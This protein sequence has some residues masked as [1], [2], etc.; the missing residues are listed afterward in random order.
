MFDWLLLIAA[1][2]LA[3]GL[4][5]MAGGGSFLT[6]PALVFTGVSPIVAN[7]TSAVA[8]F[9]GY[10]GAVAGFR[11]E[12]A[13][14]KKAKLIITFLLCLV[15]GFIG[16]LLL[17]VTSETV[18]S[19]IVPWL[20]LFAT[21]VFAF[22]DRV[23]LIQG[24]ADS[25]TSAKEMVALLFVSIYGGYFNGGLGIILLAV[26]LLSGFA[27]IHLM[28]GLKNGA[29]VC[30]GAISVATFAAAGLVLWPQALVMM[31]GTTLGG[32]Y[33]AALAK[34]IPGKLMK[35]CITVIGLLM[36]LIFFL[37]T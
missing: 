18:F 31:A 4:N 17:L 25:S 16:S 30:I 3:G 27:D 11:S 33:G 12:L 35:W 15:G 9:P 28:N 21:L 8:V 36:S 37:R 22:G 14:V 24:R 29:S 1:S 32:Y 6:L 26:F 23:I 10:I 7:A 13:L 19:A 5:A 2:I 34:R 20:L